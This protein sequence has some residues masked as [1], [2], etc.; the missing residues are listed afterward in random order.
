MLKKK[1]FK[2][3]IYCIPAGLISCTVSPLIRNPH[4]NPPNGFLGFHSTTNGMRYWEIV[5]PQIK[6]LERPDFCKKK[7]FAMDAGIFNLY[8]YQ[9]KPIA[10][11]NLYSIT[12]CFYSPGF[13]NGTSDK[14][15]PSFTCT[16]N[17]EE[18]KYSDLERDR[19]IRFFGDGKP[20]DFEYAVISFKQLLA[21]I[22]FLLIVFVAPALLFI[23]LI[24]SLFQVSFNLIKQ[25]TSN[26]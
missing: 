5:K 18:E 16:V 9:R 13:S 12:S 7:M 17:Q 25:W 23:W 20:S 11:Q 22:G 4:P 21:I 6:N 14:K 19:A 10:N 1:I 2:F 24:I 3:A 26:P 15:Q 8:C